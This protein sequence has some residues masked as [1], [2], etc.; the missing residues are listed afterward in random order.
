VLGVSENKVKENGLVREIIEKVEKEGLPFKMRRKL[1]EE[2]GIAHKQSPQRWEAW[3]GGA[4]WF[5][6]CF[7]P[8][9]SK[10]SGL[11]A[12]SFFAQLPA[13]RFPTFIVYFSLVLLVVLIG[14]G[15][16]WT[17]RIRVKRGGC[18]SEDDTIFLIKEGPYK[19]LRHPTGFSIT[20]CLVLLTIIL[21]E[22]PALHPVLS[23]FPLSFHFTVLSVF[24]N[25]AF[26]ILY[27]L[28][29]KGEEKMNIKKW[30][31]EYMKYMKEVPGFNIIKGL[32]NL[33][34]SK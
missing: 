17:S 27:P 34:K 2:R 25:L 29:Y 1:L 22:L 11:E 4:L 12:L 23:G 7:L 13:I 19:I 26:I 31:E 3:V 20:G 16:V 14:F 9:F 18:G 15:F 5:T 6:L 8:T 28:G 32:W 24:G 21:A 33:R 30:G 10:V